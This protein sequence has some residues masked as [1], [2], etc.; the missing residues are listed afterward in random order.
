MCVCACVQ[1]VYMCNMYVCL[2]DLCMLEYVCDIS[3]Y[4]LYRYMF[5]MCVCLS[6]RD[7]INCVSICVLYMCIV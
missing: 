2:C 6:K 7:N 5:Y 4:V 1:C 3:A